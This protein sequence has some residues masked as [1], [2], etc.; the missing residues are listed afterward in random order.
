MRKYFYDPRNNN[1]IVTDD[2]SSEVVVIEALK[3]VRVFV[4]GG[5]AYMLEGHE[6]NELQSAHPPKG[7]KRG[8]VQG[9]RKCS[10]CGQVGHI[11]RKCP[12]RTDI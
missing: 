6:E 9:T 4:A 10:A 11:A 2:K 8:Q 3:N 1:L 5:D 12:S 7:Q